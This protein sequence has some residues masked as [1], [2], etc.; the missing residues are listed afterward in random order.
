MSIKVKVILN[1]LVRRNHNGF[2]IEEGERP[3]QF[4]LR[5][6][7]IP[8]FSAWFCDSD[9]RSEYLI[10]QLAKILSEANDI[11]IEVKE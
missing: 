11:D 4:E 8:M 9:E 6:G 10:G 5:I 1:R 7:K 2:V 3:Y